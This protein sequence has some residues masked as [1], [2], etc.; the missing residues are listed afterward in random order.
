MSKISPKSNSISTIIRSYKSAVTRHARR[1]GFEFQWQSR[2][3]DHIIRNDVEYQ[4]IYNY[5]KN[6]PAN[7]EEDRFFQN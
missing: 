4:R 1:M 5:I 2:F 7:W 6:N 3:H